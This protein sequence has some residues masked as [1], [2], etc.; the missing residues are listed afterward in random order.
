MKVILINPSFNY[1]GGIK[2][3]GGSM[4]PLNLCYLAAY[5][6]QQNPEVEFRILDPEIQGLSHEETAK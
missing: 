4:M 5:A 3:H 6:R 2:G 1:C